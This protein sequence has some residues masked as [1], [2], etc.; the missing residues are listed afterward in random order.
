METIKAK[1]VVHEEKHFIKLL[2]RD[3]EIKIP[4]SEDKPNEV[5]SAFNKLI[6]RIKEGAFQIELEDI[7]QDLFSQVAN[8]YITQLNRE[9]Q[10]VRGEMKGY[11]L[12][13]D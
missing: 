6:V 9:I 3:E 13:K 1:V 8:E 2:I 7:G 10:E 4:I 5:K 12:V 11:G